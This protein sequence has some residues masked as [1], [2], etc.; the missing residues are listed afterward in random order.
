MNDKITRRAFVKTTARAAGIATVTGVALNQ[1]LA[2][3]AYAAG[4]E[5]IKVALVGCGG[6]WHRRCGPGPGDQ[7]PHQAVGDGRSVRGG[8]WRQASPT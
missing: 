6:A 3:G 8:V 7:G 2:A 5:T 4:D 1:M